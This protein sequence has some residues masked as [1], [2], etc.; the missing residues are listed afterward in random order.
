MS[1]PLRPEVIESALAL[2]GATGAPR[3]LRTGAAVL[4][5]LRGHNRC[6]CGYCSVQ[7]VGTGA[8]L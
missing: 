5:T 1:Y 6:V 2:H 4:Q 7:N 8:P 3:Y